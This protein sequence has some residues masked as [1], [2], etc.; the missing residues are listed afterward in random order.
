MLRTPAVPCAFLLVLAA[1]DRTGDSAATTAGSGP[2]AHGAGA[3]LVAGS[4]D[5]R[6]DPRLA[7]LLGNCGRRE[8]F[9]A[10]TS[11]LVPALVTKLAGGNV[12]PQRRA[13]E[14]LSAIGAPALDALERLFHESYGERFLAQRVQ[15]VVEVLAWMPPT[16]RGHGLILQALRH[17]QEAVRKAAARALT[18]V[19][20]PGDYDVLSEV[21]PLSGPDSQGDMLL[22]MLATDRARTEREFT[23]AVEAQDRPDLRRMLLPHVVTTRDPE[24]LARWKAVLHRTT[25]REQVFLNAALAKAGDAESLE[26]VRDQ[27]VPRGDPT[28]RQTHAQALVTVGLGRELVPLLVAGD[29][30]VALRKVA[31]DAL[32]SEPVDDTVRAALR[33]AMSDP[34]ADVRDPALTIAVRANDAGAVDVALQYLLGSRE[35][36][37][38]GLRALVARA[39]QDPALAQRVF[40]TLRAVYRGEAGSGNVDSRSLVRAIGQMKLEAAARFVLDLW[41]AGMPDIQQMPA[42]RWYALA[43]SN[44]VPAGTPVLRERFAAE[45]DPTRRMDLVMAITTFKTDETRAFLLAALDDER[46]TPAEILYLAD[47]CTQFGPGPMMAPALKRVAL[48]VND[49]IVR[50]ALNCLLWD[51]YGPSQ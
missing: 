19:G 21:L 49:P 4:L 27:L 40:E 48:R 23:A 39:D 10:D 18:R 1:C 14:D 24:V 11:D 31:V 15:N 2:S 3:V 7:H 35:E 26:F 8:P 9:L 32:D 16:E 47:R 28:L 25:G 38:V 5:P 51:F 17:P 22:A 36:F 34:L 46:M 41:K 6:N 42:H 50:P 44:T 20:L 13:R 43:A 29:P 45:T 30:D 33:A 12:D 37:E